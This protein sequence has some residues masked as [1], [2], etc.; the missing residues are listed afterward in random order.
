V[1]KLPLALALLLALMPFSDTLFAQKTYKTVDEYGNV[2]Y[3]DVPTAD[4]IEVDS[5][6]ENLYKPNASKQASPT[7]LEIE[8]PEE[9]NES[10]R[11][12]VTS[13]T[14]GQKFGL[15]QRTLTITASVIPKLDEKHYLAFYFNGKQIGEPSKESS[16]SVPLS[17]K[18]RGQRFAQ[19]AVVDDRGNTLAK[20]PN[21]KI[22]VI[23]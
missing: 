15:G 12:K 19:V 21:I 13:P 1:N 3:S 2:T 14:E 18:V 17:I 9:K 11:L 23:H 8:A 20:S 22:Y 6:P 5:T 10:Y 16:A 7:N 4:S